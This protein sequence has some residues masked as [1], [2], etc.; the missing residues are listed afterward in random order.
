MN[1]LARIRGHNAGRSEDQI[2]QMSSSSEANVTST[3]DIA[4]FRSAA[5][6]IVHSLHGRELRWSD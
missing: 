2:E 3:F 6:L 4:G 5:K 1:I